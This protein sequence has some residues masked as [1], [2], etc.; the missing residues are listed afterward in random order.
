M[1]LKHRSSEPE[2]MDSEEDAEE[3]R[4]ALGELKLINR[5]LGGNSVTSAGIMKIKEHF[6]L[7]RIKLLDAGSGTSDI[8]FQD[9]DN[10]EEITSIDK[11]FLICKM[12][13]DSGRIEKVICGNVLSFPF[14]ERSFD[15]VHASLFIHHFSDEE[16]KLL[17]EYFC[18]AAK[19]GVLINDL[20]RSYI[21]YYAFK[22]LT[23]LFSRNRLV[24]NDGLVSIKRGFKKEELIKLL[25]NT[26][27]KYLLERRW[28]FRWLL[29]IYSNERI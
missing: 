12:I 16:L 19:Y 14:K 21:S 10:T 15:V 29:I 25:D 11:N 2:L 23:L 13:R 17:L 3:I 8:F 24:K 22:L 28:A 20:Q 1:K 4:S 26:G 5:M 27:Y 18:S 7:H 9:P 6:R